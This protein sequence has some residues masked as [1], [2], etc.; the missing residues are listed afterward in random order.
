MKLF[1]KILLVSFVVALFSACESDPQVDIGQQG[2]VSAVLQAQVSFFEFRDLDNAEIIFDISI[3]E[4]DVVKESVI[5]GQFNG[6]GDKVEIETV[7]SFPATIKLTAT[8]FAETFG[9]Q[10][11]DLNLGDFLF[12]TT[13][14][15]DG[16]NQ[17][18]TNNNV[19]NAPI[20]C[21]SMLAGTYT[22]TATGAG[23]GGL[24]GLSPWT[25]TITEAEIVSVDGALVYEI[26]PAMG[27][28]MVDYY[29]A[30]GA[31]LTTA[32]FTDICSEFKNVA[33]SDGWS[34]ITDY[35]GTVDEAT[36]VITINFA[37]PWGDNGEM[38]LTPKG[39]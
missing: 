30:Y 13:E 4:G 31:S 10:V 33:L 18:F 34:T 28:I 7:T 22:L 25:S 17:T 12:L 14:T 3:N 26:T 1:N 5:Y 20:A 29:S 2:Q 38:I 6:D 19:I 32:T 27:G 39:M 9:K 15:T 16:N 36:G 23:G 24:D 35:T 8:E 11:G 21:E 37:N